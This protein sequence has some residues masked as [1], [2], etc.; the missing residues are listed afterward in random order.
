MSDGAATLAD[1]AIDGRQN[2]DIRRLLDVLDLIATERLRLHGG[3]EQGAVMRLLMRRLIDGDAAG[4]PLL[5][6]AKETGI[7]RETLR[8]KLGPLL[9]KRFLVQDEAGRYR[10][11]KAYVVASFASRQAVLAA[12]AT[13]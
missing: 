12:L 13:L 11:G 2:E 4:L 3:D 6:L 9:N 5:R 1:L 7:P 8:R 10:I